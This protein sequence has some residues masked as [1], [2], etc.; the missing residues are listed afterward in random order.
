VGILA[1]TSYALRVGT[2]FGTDFRLH[3]TAPLLL[4]FAFSHGCLHHNLATGLAN[5]SLCLGVI[6]CLIFHGI[7]HKLAARRFRILT[8]GVIIHPLW[9][10]EGYDRIGEK[11]REEYT[12]ALAG[13]LAQAFVATCLGGGLAFAGQTLRPQFDAEHYDTA[14]FFN[15]LF[16]ANLFL[17]ALNALPAFP[18]DGGRFFR[19]ALAMT[20]TRLRATELSISLA[21]VFS[22][23]MLFA[24]YFLR[25]PI[26]GFAAIALFLS[27]QEELNRERFFESLKRPPADDPEPPPPF[28][29]SP[30]D[31]VTSGLKQTVEPT[32][33]GF[34]WNA[35][36]RLWIEWKDGQVV[37]ATALIKE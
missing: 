26:V 22:I 33:T 20:Q 32:F 37:S 34:L 25:S 6:I 15:Q 31:R 11:P 4:V 30:I 19:A 36:S 9:T 8:R 14:V 2:Y 13:I 10:V 17:T 35:E 16:W 18:V 21:A 3:W 27:G 5:V 29:P 24:S 12:I 23:A 28:S 7:C 1:V